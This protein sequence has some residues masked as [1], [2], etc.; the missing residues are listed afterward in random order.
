MIF[1]DRAT[2]ETYQVPDGDILFPMGRP[3]SVGRARDEARSIAAFF[4]I[5]SE[6]WIFPL[7][8]ELRV[9]VAGGEFE[10]D[11]MAIEAD[12]AQIQELADKYNLKELYGILNARAA[13]AGK[14]AKLPYANVDW[15]ALEKR[16]DFA[17][18][19]DTPSQRH[20][21]TTDL[22]QR[23]MDR[24]VAIF[25]FFI[26]AIAIGWGIVGLVQGQVSFTSRSFRTVRNLLGHSEFRG[27]AAAMACSELLCIGL[28]FASLGAFKWGGLRRHIYFLGAGCFF[29][30]SI[31][32]LVLAMLFASVGMG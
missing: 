13:C 12:D 11:R 5:E 21:S 7:H 6:L 22:E 14:A 15:D 32:L 9:F 27:V 10:L 18:K 20:W 31:V 16:A 19:N 1:T 17:R 29:L 30:L 4:N 25:L 23:V 28:M 2:L 24:S 26:A 3:R 8:S